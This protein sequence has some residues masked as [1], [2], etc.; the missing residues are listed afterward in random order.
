MTGGRPAEIGDTVRDHGTG[1]RAIVTD[2][3]RGIPHLRPTMGSGPYWDAD[4]E[5][6]EVL[7]RARP[8]T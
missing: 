3:R 7:E 6:V 8:Q 2:I 1:R 5:Q 4:P